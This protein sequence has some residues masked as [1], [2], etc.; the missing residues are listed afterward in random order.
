MAAGHPDLRGRSATS[1]RTLASSRSSL[2]DFEFFLRRKQFGSGSSLAARRSKYDGTPA[3]AGV[4]QF[5]RRSAPGL[6]GQRAVGESAVMGQEVVPQLE[7][8]AVGPEVADVAVD[9]PAVL[10]QPVAVDVGGISAVDLDG[11]WSGVLV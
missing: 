9:G 7:A 3:H 11:G 2:S 4:R 10:G 6:A 1:L 5:G 8:Q